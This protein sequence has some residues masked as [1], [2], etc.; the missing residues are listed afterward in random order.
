MLHLE[1]TETHR[2]RVELKSETFTNYRIIE[3]YYKAIQ[4]FGDHDRVAYRLY[5]SEA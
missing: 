4:Y 1:S 5:K 3:E 2:K